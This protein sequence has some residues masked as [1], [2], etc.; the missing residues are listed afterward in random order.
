M[1]TIKRVVEVAEKEVL[2]FPWLRTLSVFNNNFFRNFCY[3]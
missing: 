1:P 3:G 2:E